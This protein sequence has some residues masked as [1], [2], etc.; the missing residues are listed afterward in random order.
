MAKYRHLILILG[1]ASLFIR[2]AFQG[3]LPDVLLMNRAAL[4][5]A[6]NAVRSG[7]HNSSPYVKELFRNAEK[8]LT[9]DPVSVMMKEQTPPSGDKHDYMSL[10]PYWWPDPSKPGGLPYIRRDGERNPE[11]KTYGDHERI[12]AMIN[13]VEVLALAFG[14][15]GKEQYA[16][17]GILQLKVWFLDPATK[18]NPNLNYGQA[19]KGVNQGRGIGIIETYG[20]RYLVD[21]MI[22]LQ[23]SKAWT[24]EIDHG[25]KA[26]FEEYLRWLQE[27]PN[28]KDE[29]GW[30]NNHGSAYD[31]QVSCIALFLGKKDLAKQILSQVGTKRIALQIEPDGSQPLELERTKSWGYSI[32]NLDALLELARLGDRVGVDLWNFQ[33]SDG[34][35]LRKAISFLL[36]YA[37]RNKKWPWTQIVPF[38]PDG[39]YFA[40]RIA[41]NKYGD[42]SYLFAAQTVVN[43]EVR[44]SRLMFYLPP[45]PVE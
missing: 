39:M 23:Q 11:Y 3:Q 12:G 4:E 6:R 22:L 16:N 26:W 34:R 41:A 45:L 28:G 30:K 40:L 27:S 29:A 7:Q 1:A 10:A 43:D 5:E 14:V 18:M 31:V 36:P 21:A 42:M 17:R 2:C 19:I 13:H 9:A 37:L 8:A 35:S 38:Q 25:I 33:T 24:P 44:G 32:M 15:S 20:F